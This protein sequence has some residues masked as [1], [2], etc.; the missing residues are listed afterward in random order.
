M[1]VFFL[2]EAF[3]VYIL[4]T[5]IPPVTVLAIVARYAGNETLLLTSSDS[6]YNTSPSTLNELVNDLLREANETG[7]YQL[8]M[9]SVDTQVIVS[10]STHVCMYTL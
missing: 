10:F 2:P 4:I 9:A 3:F 8:E 1:G 6:S 5:A 7:N